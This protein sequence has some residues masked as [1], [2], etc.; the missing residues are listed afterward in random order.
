M[1]VY[2]QAIYS[3]KVAYTRIN[4]ALLNNPFVHSLQQAV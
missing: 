1:T 2:E 3:I 4:T